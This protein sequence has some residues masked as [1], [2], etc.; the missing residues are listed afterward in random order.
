M[1]FNKRQTFLTTMA[2][3]LGLSLLYQFFW[4][5]SR[6]TTADVYAADAVRSSWRGRSNIP[7]EYASYAVDAVIYHGKY[8]RDELDVA[9][10]HCEIR[11]L[12]FAP[13]IS[14][15]NTFAGNWA[16]TLIFFGFLS[17]VTVI[18]FVRKDIIG[19][20]AVFRVQ[21]QSPF[22]RIE[23]NIIEEYDEHDIASG[24][25]S[26]AE[27]ALKKRIGTETDVFQKTEVC[28]SDYKF[29]PN[30]IG[31]F[32]AYFIPLY[33]FFKILVTERSVG[34][35]II[36]LGAVLVFVPLFVQNTNNPNFKA[37]IPDQGSLL[38]S[39]TG[40]RYKDEIYSIDDVDA[41]VVY[42]ESFQGFEYRERV[43]MGGATTISNG[44]NN[45]I[46]FRY[47]G[48]AIDFTFILDDFSDYWSFKNLMSY[49]ATRGVNVV[50]K[51]VF[52]DEFVIQQV[53]KFNTPVSI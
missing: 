49:W 46:S 8:F 29:N 47:K 35:G 38:F 6:V 10:G 12:I 32:V 26:D 43:V 1:T 41:A 18:L 19:D 11:Y 44:D 53:V 22:I 17:L 7:M 15:K 36:F 24:P 34:P 2:I 28:A 21:A 13:D 20:Q 33:W 30:A 3:W 37:R 14:R 16:Y 42:L 48:Q 27:Q 45:T 4:V 5:F 51:K 40:V 50:L 31:I 25:T 39:T 52:E 9:S 23:K